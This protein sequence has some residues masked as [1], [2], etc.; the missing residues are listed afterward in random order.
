M[1]MAI[2]FLTLVYLANSFVVTNSD[3]ITETCQLN[4]MNYIST[5]SFSKQKNYYYHDEDVYI[6]SLTH[7]LAPIFETSGLSINIYNIANNT[8][9]E[10]QN[11]DL[12]HNNEEIDIRIKLT[13]ND[14]MKCTNMQNNEEYY[15]KRCKLMLEYINGPKD[16]ILKTYNTSLIIEIPKIIELEY[17]PYGNFLSRNGYT[18]HELEFQKNIFKEDCATKI[19]ENDMVTYGDN[20]CLFLKGIDK[21]S[22]KYR[23]KLKNVT[24]TFESEKGQNIVDMSDLV[25][26]KSITKNEDYKGKMYIILPIIYTGRLKFKLTI[27]LA[28]EEQTNTFNHDYEIFEDNDLDYERNRNSIIYL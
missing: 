16:V 1:P 28:D 6:V 13:D 20:V 11:I 19:G 9:H 15:T 27:T 23:F 17:A 8:K 4:L 14:I 3:C 25:E 2:F 22:S 26:S 24:L 12:I 18:I 21:Y 10:I 5:L 7:P